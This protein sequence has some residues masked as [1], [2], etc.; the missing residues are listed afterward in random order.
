MWCKHVNGQDLV[1]CNRLVGSREQC[2]NYCTAHKPCL[3]YRTRRTYCDL[4]ASDNSCPIIKNITHGYPWNLYQ[5]YNG[6]IE[7]PATMATMWNDIVPSSASNYAECFAKH[8]G[9]LDKS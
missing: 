4:I 3:G 9:K 7:K 1:S 6:T 5:Y 2:Q 8:L